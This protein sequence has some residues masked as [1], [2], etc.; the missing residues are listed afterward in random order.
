MRNELP[1][2]SGSTPS[3]AE[4]DQSALGAHRPPA[5]STE[6]RLS[7]RSLR[8]IVDAETFVLVRPGQVPGTIPES[9][10]VGPPFISSL[11]P[12]SEQYVSHRRR[13][14]DDSSHSSAAPRESNLFLQAPREWPGTRSAAAENSIPSSPFDVAAET[15]RAQRIQFPTVA[16]VRTYTVPGMRE[17]CDRRSADVLTQN[18]D[19]YGGC[20]PRRRFDE[21]VEPTEATAS[22]GSAWSFPLPDTRLRAISTMTEGEMPAEGCDRNRDRARLSE[23][24]TV[25]PSASRPHGEPSASVPTS[26]LHTLLNS[27]SSGAVHRPSSADF[28]SRFPSRLLPPPP[29]TLSTRRD[30]VFSQFRS[31][32]S[33]QAVLYPALNFQRVATG[34][35]ETAPSER[36]SVRHITTATNIDEEDPSS[37]PRSLQRTVSDPVSKHI[38]RLGRQPAVVSPA[39]LGVRDVSLNLRQERLCDDG[40]NNNAHSQAAERTLGTGAEGGLD[41]RGQQYHSPNPGFSERTEAPQ[42]RGKSDNAEMQVSEAVALGEDVVSPV[43]DLLQRDDRYLRDLQTVR[44]YGGQLPTDAG[45]QTEQ[46]ARR[47]S[48]VCDVCGYTATQSSDLKVS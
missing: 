32:S 38:P 11:Q 21:L 22:L 15:M 35:T 36:L 34:N 1:S 44:E 47:G 43:R 25:A 45:Y 5:S 16:D 27:P 6:N 13:L 12:A 18:L 31:R 23:Y 30:M 48:H 28:A 17:L 9:A 41:R 42:E 20:K 19:T 2:P 29:E 24:D 10:H 26:A 40:R 39:P 3:A 33:H 8:S 4:P 14:A 46:R 37:Q 7:S